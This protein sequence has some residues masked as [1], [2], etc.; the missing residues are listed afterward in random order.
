MDRSQCYYKR[1]AKIEWCEVRIWYIHGSIFAI[2]GSQGQIYEFFEG[3]GEVRAGILGGG[4]QG[5]QKGNSVGIFIP[6]SK[7]KKTLGVGVG[8]G[9]KPLDPLDLIRE[10]GSDSKLWGDFY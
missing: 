6:T 9:V 4:G 7:I 1:T 3:G 2:P 10:L 5:P 8:V